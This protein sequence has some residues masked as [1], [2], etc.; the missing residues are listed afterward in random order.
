M[1]HLRSAIQKPLC[2]ERPVPLLVHISNLWLTVWFSN[3]YNL[4]VDINVGSSFIARFLP[5]IFAVKSMIGMWHSHSVAILSTTQRNQHKC[6][7]TSNFT[8]ALDGP[9]CEDEISIHPIWHAQQALLKPHSKHCIIVTTKVSGINIF[10]LR[11]IG[12]TR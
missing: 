12:G 11:I 1:P 3:G 9:Y 8:A 10:E 6:R 2:M 5:E 4:A 7:S